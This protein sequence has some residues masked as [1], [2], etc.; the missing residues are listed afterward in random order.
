ME[1]I[2]PECRKS[3]EFAAVFES[4]FCWASSAVAFNCPSCG[5]TAYF[6]PQGE[7]I[8]VGFLGAGPT[9][10]P[11]PGVRYHAEV[12]TQRQDQFLTI[13]WHGLS[14]ELPSANVYISTRYG[15][16]RL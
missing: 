4:A 11:I 8:E 6:A 10:D 3:I 9:L 14:K 2:C 13:S 1:I 16:H 5:N 12:A 15:A 7:D